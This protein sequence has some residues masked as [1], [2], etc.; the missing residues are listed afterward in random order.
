MIA[1]EPTEKNVRVRVGN[2]PEDNVST[3]V[4]VGVAAEPNAAK[5]DGATP[6]VSANA[7]GEGTVVLLESWKTNS[8]VPA[9]GALVVSDSD[10]VA[11]YEL[12]AAT[13]NVVP[14]DVVTK[15]LMVRPGRT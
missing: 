15:L 13:V 2:A 8:C 4:T 11:V 10:V 6:L 5:F 3:S 7:K 14:V 9:T 12:N 1:P